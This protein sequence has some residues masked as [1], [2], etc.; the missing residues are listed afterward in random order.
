VRLAV[1]FLFG[2][3]T[4]GGLGWVFVEPFSGRVA[5]V[6]FVRKAVE[7]R[8]AL[9]FSGALAE[10]DRAVELMPQS[11]EICFERAE[12]RY[13]AGDLEGS[14]AEYNRLVELNP[15]FAAA[16]MGRSTIYQRQG[17]HREAIDEL[18]RF[19][20][21]RPAWDP[22]PLNQRAYTRALAAGQV[23]RAELE[24]GLAD[25][26]RAIALAGG[27]EPALLD[28]RGYLLHLLGRHDEALKDLERALAATE[29]AVK[30]IQEAREITP[31]QGRALDQMQAVMLHHRGL[32]HRELGNADK[33]KADLRRADELGY[34]PAKGVY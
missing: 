5:A 7:K 34:D 28:T 27:D 30:K 12:V 2:L 8:N 10:L 24:A 14:L 13:D 29:A 11:P 22:L 31:L 16:Y 21:L 4:V 23:D 20:E 25:A 26:E 19:V 17:R 9:D 18:A 15:H 6:W 32:V 3:V 1:A 33:A